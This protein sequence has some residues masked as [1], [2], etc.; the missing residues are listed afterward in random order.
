MKNIFDLSGKVAIVVGGSRGLGRGMAVGL[1]DAGATV[2]I[3]SR[4]KEALEQAA[5]E[6]S[7]ETQ[8]NV[9][10]I[11][12]DVT[13]IDA[14]SEFVKTVGERFGRIDI[15]VNSAGIN[16]RKPAFEYTESEWD[17]VTDTQMKYV[18]F[19]NQAVA[20]FMV[21][22]KIKGRII[23]V[24]SISSMVGLKNMIA[25]CSSKG[26]IVQMTKA[27]AN[28]WAQYGITVNA[29]C[30]GYCFTEMTRPLLSDPAVLA[31]YHEK[32]PMGRLGEPEDMASTVVYLA[33]DASS[34]VTGQMIY[35]DGGWIVN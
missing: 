23:N 9:V 4:N 24:G 34:Y 22:K 28:E 33:S 27:L 16:T 6:M 30:P 15:L 7:D 1:A 32:I 2:V 13:S 17:E 35:V 8:G 20:R 19:M 26:A 3:A 5:I 31:K 29:I 25:Y 21:D 18:F 12:L 14:I 10:G 11:P